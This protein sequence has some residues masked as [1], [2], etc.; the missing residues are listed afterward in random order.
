MLIHKYII[1]F[2]KYGKKENEISF[3]WWNSGTST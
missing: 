1:I 2:Y 3:A